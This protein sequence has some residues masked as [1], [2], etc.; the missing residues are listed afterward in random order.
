[1]FCPVNVFLYGWSTI[2]RVVII[3]WWDVET[4]LHCHQKTDIKRSL[5]VDD[6]DEVWEMIEHVIEFF[7][8]VWDVITSLFR[9]D[10]E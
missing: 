7:V 9:R 10:E 2:F 1:M 6:L 8:M 4:Y 5:V 3:T